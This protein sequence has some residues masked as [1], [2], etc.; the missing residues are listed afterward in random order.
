MCMRIIPARPSRTTPNISGSRPAET[1]FTIVAPASMAAAATSCLRV[2]IE[3]GAST[4]PA[5]RLMTGS[6][7]SIS[8]SAVTGCDPG[9]VDSPP[10]SRRS[11]PS[12]TMRMPALTAASG[13]KNRPPSEKESGV[14]LITPITWVRAPTS[15]SR[16]PT[17]HGMRPAM[18]PSYREPPVASTGGALRAAP[19]NQLQGLGPGPG[20]AAEPSTHGRGHRDRPGLLHA[21]HGHT[22]VFRLD[23]HEDAPRLERLLQRVGD[24]RGEPLLH[25]KLLRQQIHEPGHLRQS[26][27]TPVPVR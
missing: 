7:R 25:L 22:E 2:S 16:S 17:R 12:P 21:A 1:S 27:D 8:S 26:G 20:V 19:A 11:A 3:S 6:T 18:G 5:R 24:L 15:S 9:R 13:S 4:S 10:T 23:E 14:T